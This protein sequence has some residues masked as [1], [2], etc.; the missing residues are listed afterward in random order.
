VHRALIALALC[1]IAAGT[2]GCSLF[3]H[4]SQQQQFLDALNRGNA[5]QASQLWLAMKPAN[6]AKLSHSQG[7][8]PSLSP[9]EI[10]AQVLRHEEE[11]AAAEGDDSE[12]VMGDSDNG[13]VTSEQIEMPGLESDTTGGKLSNLPY[14]NVPG[15][16]ESPPETDSP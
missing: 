1:A 5:A 16:V 11:K 4:E 10:Q 3:H 6:R 14:Y 8:T 2:G 12:T 9:D 13:D 15:H 7:L